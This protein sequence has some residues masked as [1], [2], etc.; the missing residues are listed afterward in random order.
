MSAALLVQLRES[1]E[2]QAVM[3]SM[4]DK[5]PVVAPYRPANTMEAQNLQ[6]ERIKHQMGMQEGFDLLMMHL[7]G[8]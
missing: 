1:A 3:K 6:L 8:K 5:R 7:L 2:F 4:Q